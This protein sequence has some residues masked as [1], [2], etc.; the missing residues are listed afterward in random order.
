MIVRQQL[1]ALQL[2]LRD[3]HSVERIHVDS[4]ELLDERE[5]PCGDGKL[6][7]TGIQKQSSCIFRTQ[8]D[9]MRMFDVL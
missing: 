3:K 5:M 6:K 9:V 8:R 4:R 1:H 7:I 2:R